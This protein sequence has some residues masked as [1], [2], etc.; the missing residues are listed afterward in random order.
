CHHD[1]VL[2]AWI[3]VYRQVRVSAAPGSNPPR[4]ASVSVRLKATSARR[5]L[6]A[7]M[8]SLATAESGMA[9]SSPPT[10]TTNTRRRKPLTTAP[11]SSGSARDDAP[12][13]AAGTH[14]LADFH[15]VTPVRRSRHVAKS[16]DRH[17][18][19]TEFPLPRARGRVGVG[20]GSAFD[21]CGDQAP[22]LGPGAVVVADVGVAEQVIQD[23]PGVRGALPISA[24][25]DDGLVRCHALRRVQFLQFGGRLEGPV[26]T[27]RLRPGDV[28][29]AGDVP[30]A[31]GALLR[32]VLRGEQ[33]AAEFLGG[34][35]VDQDH[36]RLPKIP[37]HLI[38]Q[39]PDRL[40]RLARRVAGRLDGR[41]IRDELAALVLPF[42]P[43]AVHQP[44][45]LVA[46]VLEIPDEPGGKPV[47]VVAVGDH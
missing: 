4:T 31:L 10:T 16:H 34:T 29:R 7:R 14:A 17:P 39:G 26:L 8:F 3:W 33:L 41:R 45:V 44:G 15:N 42:L 36:A 30:T 37:Q 19:V 24:I 46:V 20:A 1:D 43:T 38:P 12:P 5:T 13:K 40:V 32:E 6:P 27:H 22:P 25:G 18:A 21:R 23:E 47:V 28:G 9:A 35:D 2:M 11:L